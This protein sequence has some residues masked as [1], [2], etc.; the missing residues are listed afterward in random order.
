MSP[1]EHHE[2]YLD[3]LCYDVA[4]DVRETS[5]ECDFMAWCVERLA[6]GRLEAA[7]ELAAGPGYHALEFAR[8]GLRSVAL[9]IEPSM[10][11]HLR[12]KASAVAK[13]PPPS[14]LGRLGGLRAQP[15]PLEVVEGDM[16][17]WRAETPVDLAYT[18]FGSF[19]YL[20]TTDDARQHFEAVAA[21]LRT[22]GLYVIEL[23]HPRKFL[24]GDV[25]TQDAWVRERDGV[26]V[27]VR[28]DTGRAVP[29]P[30]THCMDVR[31]EFEVEE[32]GRRRKVR[33]RGRQ[34]VWFAPEIEALSRGRFTLLSWFGAMDRKVAYDYG[35]KAWRMVAVLQRV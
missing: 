6:G 22:G 31:S 28:W 10:V 33:T 34:R 35:R 14:L 32:G 13:A 30:V 21:S 24:R 2:L 27:T 17:V 4:F 11:A 12:R 23:P 16:R 29:D 8:R 15:R 1:S 9:D 18:L 25:T 3:P 26:K 5:R 19:C 7:L 20:L